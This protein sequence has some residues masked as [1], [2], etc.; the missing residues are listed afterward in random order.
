MEPGTRTVGNKK[1]MQ[2]KFKY[3]LFT[4]IKKNIIKANVKQAF[5]INMH[6]SPLKKT[7]KY[8]R[9]KKKSRKFK[10]KNCTLNQ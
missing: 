7:Q 2:I 3:D 9:R 5:A 1:K 10:T 8:W 4:R 6:Y